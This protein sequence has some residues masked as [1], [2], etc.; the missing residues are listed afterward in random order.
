MPPTA[1]I[2]TKLIS[3]APS[4]LQH[5]CL[6]TPLVTG[7]C[8]K[9]E[10]IRNGDA[11][12]PMTTVL[13]SIHPA[14]N[15]HCTSSEHHD[16]QPGTDSTTQVSLQVPALGDHL[17]VNAAAAVAVTCACLQK[18]CIEA[19]HDALQYGKPDQLLKLMQSVLINMKERQWLSDWTPPP[20]RM[21]VHRLV[22]NVVIVN[23][24]Y[25]ANPASMLSALR[26]VQNVGVSKPLLPV[27]RLAVLGSMSELGVDEVMYHQNVMAAASSLEAIDFMFWGCKWNGCPSTTAGSDDE[28]NYSRV[29][30][31][32]P[33]NQD[34]T[35]FDAVVGWIKAV[36]SEKQVSVVL[37]KGSRI[38]GM[39][40]VM[41]WLQS[42]TICETP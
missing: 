5:R 6:E 39:E 35:L 12:I 2:L 36:N 11:W 25:N 13:L 3:H 14:D 24:T 37:L 42:H 41:H 22:G 40:R 15:T 32:I 8:C 21:S 34:Q 10:L 29:F 23:D 17:A 7:K 28:E 1:I 16:W 33:G 30:M 27:R 4:G 18:Q 31:Q 19:G 26:T 9:T 38:A 20:G